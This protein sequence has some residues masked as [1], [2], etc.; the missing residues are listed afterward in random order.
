MLKTWPTDLP[1]WTDPERLGGA[2]CFLNTRVPVDALFANL[3]D[4]VS[5]D[6][7]LTAFDGVKREHAL[8]ILEYVRKI[9]RNEAA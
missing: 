2:P 6:E 8:A 9:F 3:E 7:F 5:L 4:G 1:I